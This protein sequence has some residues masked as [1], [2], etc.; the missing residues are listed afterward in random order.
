MR[1]RWGILWIVLLLPPAMFELWALW[2]VMQ[3]DTLSELV[4]PLLHSNPWLWWG[5]LALYL[6]T[7]AILCWHWWFQYRGR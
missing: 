5:G 7:G 3:G 1:K 2:N 6:A 4:I